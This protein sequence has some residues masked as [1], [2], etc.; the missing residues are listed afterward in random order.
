MFRRRGGCVCCGGITPHAEDATQLIKVDYDVLELIVGLRRPWPERRRGLT[1]IND[2]LVAHG[3]L[4][5]GRAY[6]AKPT[7]CSKPNS[8]ASGG[9]ATL[10]RGVV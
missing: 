1:K 4:P 10:W 9:G 3:R 8:P 5:D 2:N 6:L 7:M